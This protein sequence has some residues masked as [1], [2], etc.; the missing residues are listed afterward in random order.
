MGLAALLAVATLAIGGPTGARACRTLVVTK[1]HVAYRHAMTI[2][3][4]ADEARSCDWI[5]VTPG[6]YRA[7]VVVRTPDIHLRG[8][9]RNGVVL[10]GGHRRGTGSTWSQT[11]SRS[12]TLR[13]A[14][15][16]GALL[17]QTRAGNATACHVR[18]GETHIWRL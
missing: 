8:L 14:T 6:V 11:A 17:R 12:R 13:S 1:A 10:D 18:F 3:A 15:S 5:L 4:A 7:P 16:T 9:H 2:E